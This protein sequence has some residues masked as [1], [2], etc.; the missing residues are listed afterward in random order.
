VREDSPPGAGDARGLMLCA[1]AGERIDA[2][3]DY[4]DRLAQTLS[5]GGTPFDICVWNRAD[6]G[7][8]PLPDLGGISSVVIHYNPFSWGRRGVAPR[9][10]QLVRRLASSPQRPAVAL[11]LHERFVGGLRPKV[12]VLG[13]VQ[14]VQLRTILRTVD[15]VLGST[16]AW[17]EW[18]G[19]HFT[20]PVARLP[21]ASSLP[22]ARA[23]AAATRA[24]LEAPDNEPVLVAYGTGHPSRDM[25]LIRAACV[26]AA[27]EHGSALLL[28]LGD[29]APA[30]DAGPSVRVCQ[31]GP[32]PLEEIAR[33]IAAGDVFLAPF[34][35]GAS[36]R[37][38]TL[39]GAMQQGLPVIGAD[40][41][42]TDPELR[43]PTS[44]VV[45]AERTPQ[46]FANAAAAL[47]GD[48]HAQARLGALARA[49]YE[50]HCDWPVARDALIGA[51]A[52]VAR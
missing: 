24:E 38:T 49:F 18:A 34:V 25:R 15:L 47:A 4:A 28:N 1:T 41:H 21:I 26:R 5:N 46:A 3:V 51:L 16:T 40:G 8:P 50:Q 35:D 7:R 20:G 22:D 11:M 33:L 36:L 14:R 9:L 45:L 48:T 12:A 31:P 37:R 23:E 19:R 32:L 10:V 30:V 42:L 6:G 27:A 17:V 44:G 13:A 39:V 29:G 43:D 52:R 2:I